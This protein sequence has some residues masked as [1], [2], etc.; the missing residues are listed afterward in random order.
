[1]KEGKW[2]GYILPDFSP[3]EHMSCNKCVALSGVFPI[4]SDSH[5]MTSY[6]VKCDS[7]IADSCCFV[8]HGLS[9]ASL[10]P[11]RLLKQRN[12][13]FLLFCFV[14]FLHQYCTRGKT[15]CCGLF[16]RCLSL[17]CCFLKGF[18]WVILFIYISVLPLCT[19]LNPV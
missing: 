10:L 1:M 7:S 9:S 17:T 6:H 8:Q 19:D 14:L 15:S 2:C 18:S 5:D 4:P 13:F 11:H 12:G 16:K 3:E